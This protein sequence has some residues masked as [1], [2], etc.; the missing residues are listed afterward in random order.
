MNQSNKK[1]VM[2]IIIEPGDIAV[3]EAMESVIRDYIKDTIAKLMANDDPKVSRSRYTTLY[4]DEYNLEL[5]INVSVIKR[6]NGKTAY[7][8]NIESIDK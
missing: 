8:F 7:C 2:R 4:D 3:T 1:Q 5:A 6:K